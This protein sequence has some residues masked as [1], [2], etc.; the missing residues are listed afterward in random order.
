MLWLFGPFEHLMD[1][2][3]WAY[4]IGGIMIMFQF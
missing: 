4:I 2:D 1:F 3:E